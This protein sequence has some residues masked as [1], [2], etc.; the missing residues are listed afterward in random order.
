LIVSDRIATDD[1]VVDAAYGDAILRPAHIESGVKDGVPGYGE[2]VSIFQT[3]AD[4]ILIND[5]I[6]C[7]GYIIPKKDEAAGSRSASLPDVIARYNDGRVSVSVP[8]NLD[9]AATA[10]QIAMAAR[11][12]VP[13]YRRPRA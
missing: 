6:A 4:T 9:L 7:G 12:R 2:P 1:K 13:A 3:N 5:R 10:E 8:I 11:N